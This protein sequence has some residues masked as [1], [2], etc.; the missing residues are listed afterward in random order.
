MLL[1][2]VPFIYKQI[3]TPLKGIEIKDSTQKRETST[4]PT[5]IDMQQNL[6]Y[7]FNLNPCSA[8]A[9]CKFILSPAKQYDRNS[10]TKKLESTIHSN[11]I[12]K[13]VGIFNVL[14]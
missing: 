1:T 5:L 8:D 6:Q 11:E 7:L 9:Q 12:C 14:A 4:Q 2:D 10:V 13:I 3:K